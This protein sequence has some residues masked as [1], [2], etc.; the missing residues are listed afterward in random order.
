MSEVRL[1]I[2]EASRALCG[3]I[4]GSVAEAAVAG[5]SAQP[6][7]IEELQDAVALWVAKADPSATRTTKDVDLLVER[8]DLAQINQVMRELGFEKQELRRLV[9]FVDPE[10][11][12]RRSGVHLVWAGE[13]VLPSYAHA[14]PTLTATVRDPEGFW[15]LDLPALVGMKLTSLRDIDK[16][17]IAD[18]LRVDMVSPRL[19][20]SLPPD[21]RR[22]LEDIEATLEDE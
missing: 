15:V 16:V 5:L 17:H 14:A 20:R 6:E 21:L 18:L 13:K 7:T 1:N 12:S 10:A 8:S 19:R 22:R 11:P 4:H 2:L 3:A 9:L